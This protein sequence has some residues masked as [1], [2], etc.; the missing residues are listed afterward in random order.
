MSEKY[1]DFGNVL[2]A[3]IPKNGLTYGV[4][5][6]GTGLYVPDRVITNKYWE[7]RVE[8]TNEWIVSKTGIRERR[9]LDKNEVTSDMGIKAAEQ[10]MHNA[11][12]SP[13]S[14]DCIIVTSFTPDYVLPSTA[15]IIKEAIGAT[16]AMPLDFGQVA[17][18]GIVYGIQVG[19][20]LLQNKNYENI[21]VIGSEAMSRVTN[22]KDRATCVFFGDACGALI[23]RRM[24]NQ[25]M[26][27]L[28]WDL[29]SLLS[30]DVFVPH[31]GSRQ[32]VNHKSIVEGKHYLHMNGQAV[33]KMATEVLP[34]SIQKAVDK[35]GFTVD[36]VDFFLIHQAN[37]KIVKEVL[38]RLDVSEEKTLFNVHKFGNTGAGTLPTVLHEAIKNNKLKDDSLVVLSSV[39][40]GFIWGSMVLR[41]SSDHSDFE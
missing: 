23:L 10:A 40:A 28:S 41:Y 7:D 13:E 3:D 18:A 1:T 26:G 32:P 38:N 29:D 9:F 11:D 31:G 30:H 25:S 27:V 5:I 14:I 22:P 34:K 21:L 33:W 16:N 24:K 35:A 19:S 36:D 8:T 2:S 20:H 6:L 17:C 4:G 15:L 39:G 37:E 12:I